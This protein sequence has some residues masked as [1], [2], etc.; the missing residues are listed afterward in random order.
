M[1]QCAA[2]DRCN[3]FLNRST[4]RPRRSRRTRRTKRRKPI[5]STSHLDTPPV[6]PQVDRWP[7]KHQ[8]KA[9]YY[10]YKEDGFIDSMFGSSLLPPILPTVADNPIENS[11]L[12]QRWSQGTWSGLLVHSVNWD[13]YRSACTNLPER[14]GQRMPP[15]ATY[16]H[17]DYAEYYS[18]P[19]PKQTVCHLPSPAILDNEHAS[20]PLSFSLD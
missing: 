1:R 18:D 20:A 12:P 10:Y 15:L 11:P 6:S 5:F 14:T 8:P 19:D 17:R 4:S 13:D 9:R 7:S 3:V 16:R 2:F